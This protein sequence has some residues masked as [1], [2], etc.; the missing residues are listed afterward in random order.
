MKTPVRRTSTA[1]RRAATV[2][3]AAGTALAGTLLA[4]PGAHAADSDITFSDVVVNKGQPVVLG[5]GAEVEVPV[6]YTLK[7]KVRLDGFWVEL[8]RGTWGHYEDRLDNAIQQYCPKSSSGG[9]TYYD[10]DDTLFYSPRT[11]VNSDA[12]TWKTYGTAVKVGGGYDDDLL[13]PSVS[14][15]RASLIES[16]D[17]SPE[18]VTSGEP[19]TVKGTLKRANWNTRRYDLYGGQRVTLQFK[20]A[21][22]TAYTSVRTITTTPTGA[23]RTT[24]TASKDGTWRWYY[25]GNSVTGAKATTGDYVDVR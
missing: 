7:T 16:A 4:A 3:A 2:L 20:A 17:A 8:Y 23:M 18:P 11:F 5:T 25:A 10:C 13:A 1:G 6:T 19:I 21:G 24:V 22:T 15:R 9:Y 12:G 14:I